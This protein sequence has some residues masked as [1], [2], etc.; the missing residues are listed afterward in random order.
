MLGPLLLRQHRFGE[1]VETFGLNGSCEESGEM[2]KNMPWF[3]GV[4]MALAVV[5]CGDPSVSDDGELLTVSEAA[6][7]VTEDN[8]SVAV[9]TAY[10]QADPPKPKQPQSCIVC[11][12]NGNG[13]TS[14]WLS[15]YC[16]NK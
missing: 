10:L 13:G 2:H 6:D 14:C 11:G 15:L 12:P 9:K 3:V 4:L 8:P 7:G 5:G 16:S 1:E